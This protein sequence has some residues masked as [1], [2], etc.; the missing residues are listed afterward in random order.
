MC[1]C[2][3]PTS[4]ATMTSSK[5]G[6]VQGKPV[7]FIN[8]HHSRTR[9]V[10]LCG[11]TVDVETGC[12]E[13]GLNKSPEGY[14]LAWRDGRMRA[15]HRVFW[16][17]AN[18]PIPDG[19]PLDHLCINPSCVNPD[20][21]EPVTHLENVRRSRR[22]KLTVED[23]ADIKASPDESHAELGRRYG[24]SWTVIWSIRNGRTWK[25]VEAA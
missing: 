20:H 17:E 10:P 7:R 14:G 5:R 19:L 22:A 23:V 1:G 18:G 11:Y 8:G 4:L 2:G 21:L 15:A 13:W 16:E 3:E 25:D 9:G 12:W 6:V 24:V